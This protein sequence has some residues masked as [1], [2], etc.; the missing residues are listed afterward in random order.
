MAGDFNGDGCDTVSIYRPAESRVFII[1]K[2][3]ADDG[4]LGA[5][6]LAYDFGDPG[7]KPFV[8]DFDADGIETIG[9]HRESTGL[10]YI[11]NTH[12]Q[13]NADQDYI[14][15][16]PDD[17]LVAGDWTGDGTASPALFRPSNRTV[18]YRFTNTPGNA[19]H[20]WTAGQSTWLPVAGHLGLP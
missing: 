13:G 12:T 7:D 20:Q 18:Y 10:V 14:F 16:D 11:R 8:G 9:L 17:R 19:D 3:G 5:A 6:D 4:G 15:G 2:L 1:N